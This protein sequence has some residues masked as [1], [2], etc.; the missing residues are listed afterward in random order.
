MRKQ[1]MLRET[2]IEEIMLN[3]Q[4]GTCLVEREGGGETGG[5]KEKDRMLH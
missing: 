3:R 1:S 5:R 4:D 2:G